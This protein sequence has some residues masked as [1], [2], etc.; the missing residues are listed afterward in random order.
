[1]TSCL[2]LLV[3]LLYNDHVMSAPVHSSSVDSSQERD[4]DVGRLPGG[5]K[6]GKGTQPRGNHQG[7]GKGSVGASLYIDGKASE[8][9]VPP[10]PAD[11]IP[12]PPPPA[13]EL[14]PPPPPADEPPPPPPADEIPPDQQM[15]PLP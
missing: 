10:P 5:V 13:D 14:P 8:S 4:D 12:P 11:E 7:R 2:V 3:V 15:E 1:M 9:D 6:Y